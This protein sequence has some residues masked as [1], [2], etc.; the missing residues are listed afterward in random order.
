MGAMAEETVDIGPDALDGY[1]RSNTRVFVKVSGDTYYVT[2]T[3]GY[4]RVQDCAKLN[5]KGHFIDCSELVP[6]L[7]EVLHL[8]C[9]DGRTL[10][11]V[12]PE[13][14]FYESLEA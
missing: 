1:L 2:H 12:A 8:P 10:M 9:I 6:T 4:W 3:D 5:E 14:E 11:E 13:A 7:H